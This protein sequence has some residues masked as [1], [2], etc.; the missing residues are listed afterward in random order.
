M[1]A[2]LKHPGLRIESAA[3]QERSEGKHHPAPRFF[4]SLLS[5]TLSSL[6]FSF[7]HSSPPSVKERRFS[8][9]LEASRAT[10]PPPRCLSRKAKTG[11]SAG[12]SLT[13]CE[14]SLSCNV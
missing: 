2:I 13:L 12:L 14:N 7:P 1:S 6:L 8:A 10:S 3:D 9:G 11:S 5:R 4:P